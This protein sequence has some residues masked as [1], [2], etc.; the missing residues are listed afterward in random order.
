M[1]PGRG[2]RLVG[3]DKIDT[4][5]DLHIQ[6]PLTDRLREP[7]ESRSLS[8]TRTSTRD[9]GA[10]AESCDG[11]QGSGQCSVCD[12]EGMIR[13]EEEGVE[14]FCN[15][16]HGTGVCNVCQGSGENPPTFDPW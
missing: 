16:C 5:L 12:G 13:S 2:D 15:P 4:D 8:D 3:H 1:L 7:S 10:M 11:C 9:G 6:L 14:S